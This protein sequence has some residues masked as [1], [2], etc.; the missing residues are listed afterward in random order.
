[1]LRGEIPLDLHWHLL[2]AA[3]YRSHHAI[4]L[5]GLFPRS[6]SATIAGRD[7]KT[8]DA[9]DTLLHLCLHAARSGGD[10]LVWMKDIERSIVVDRP[11]LDELVARARQARCGPEVGLML[12]RTKRAPYTL[13]S[14]TG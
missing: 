4:D 6:R 12:A 8:F 5:D 14:L 9:V 7:V 1:M 3:H 13:R 10:R 11:D 2:Y